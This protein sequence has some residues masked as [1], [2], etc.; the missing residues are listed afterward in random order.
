[1]GRPPTAPGLA[2]VYTPTQP[3]NP[4]QGVEG[5][6]GVGREDGIRESTEEVC[7]FTLKVV[8]YGYIRERE[9]WLDPTGVKFRL[10]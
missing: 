4:G 10:N 8:G 3:P 1:M 6:G 7:T 9:I 2:S 5:R